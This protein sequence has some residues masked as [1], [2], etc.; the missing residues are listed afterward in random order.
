[1]D[2]G[3]SQLERIRAAMIAEISD[4]RSAFP[5]LVDDNVDAH[6]SDVGP[7]PKENAAIVSKK[8]KR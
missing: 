2:C 8:R 1:M 7:S 6:V 3:I 5:Q 4:A